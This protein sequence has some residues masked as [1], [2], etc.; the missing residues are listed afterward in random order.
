[1]TVVAML[2][3]ALL[4]VPLL[5]AGLAHL[6]WSMGLNWPI[7]DTRLLA[8]TVVGT[9]DVVRMPPKPLTFLVSLAILAAG[10]LALSLADHSSGG[11]WLDLAGIAAAIVLLARGAA[12]YT[13]GWRQRFPTEPFASYDRKLYTPL[14]LAIGLGFV[15]LVVMRHL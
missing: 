14:I 5:A 11:L 4:F 2:I 15:V 1:M 7:R 3:A 12:G 9:P 8:R 13:S 6:G 10:V